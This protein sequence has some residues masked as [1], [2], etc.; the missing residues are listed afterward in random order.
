MPYYEQ[1][2][3]SMESWAKP[4]YFAILS[5]ADRAATAA[6]FAEQESKDSPL[7]DREC[8]RRSGHSGE[9]TNG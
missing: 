9:S 6:T 4:S 2:F 3:G 7:P 8:P 5:I 1:Q